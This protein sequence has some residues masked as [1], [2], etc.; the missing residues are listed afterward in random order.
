MNKGSL[1]LIAAKAQFLTTAAAKHSYEAEALTPALLTAI[2]V[3]NAMSP[4]GCYSYQ[5]ATAVDLHIN[6]VNGILNALLVGRYPGLSFE[7]EDSLGS[8]KVWKLENR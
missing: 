3:I 2:D 8:P 1:E 7:I 6:T 4:R 5:I